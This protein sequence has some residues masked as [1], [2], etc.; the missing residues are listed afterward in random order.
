M[1]LPQAQ[2]GILEI[3]PY[4]AGKSATKPTAAP[5]KLS[6]NE[7][8]YGC[9]PK[10]EQAYAEAAADMNRYPNAGCSAVRAAI[11]ETY[12]IPTDNIICGAGSDELLGLLVQAFAGEGDEVLYPEHG[13]LMYKIYALG[14][15]AIPIEATETNLKTDVDALL[16]SVTERTKIVFLANP[17]N[18]TGSY[19]SGAELKR[20]RDG[21]PEH[22]VL[23]IDGAYAEYV[24]ADDYSCGLDLATTTQN[25][26]MLRTFSKIYGLPAVRLGWAVGSDY[27]MDILGR[28]RSPFN[29]T[30]AAQAAG[31]AAMRDTTW[32]Y[33]QRDINNKA[34]VSL[35][36]EF[37]S[38]GL[39]VYPSV[40]NF[41]LVEL[42][43]TERANEVLKGL[44]AKDIYVRDVVAYKLPS[45]LR[46]SIGTDK[47][48]AT[49]MVAMRE[50]I[51]A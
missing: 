19:I 13:F 2:A 23:A 12:D 37:Q 45:C 14:N 43:S 38:L 11:S 46:I 26:V 7:N 25:T 10:A 49:L 31:A 21:L 20:L 8:P 5:I 28:I 47:E 3:K 18:P 41:I 35:I 51:D 29:V 48:N 34:L 32:M 42:G 4:K 39:G 24:E 17:N 1:A 44:A 22:V 36:S 9:S 30:S 50:L 16:A 6:S 15:G 33:E 40:G 27:I